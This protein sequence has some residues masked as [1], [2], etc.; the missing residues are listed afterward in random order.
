LSWNSEH[1]QI[2]SARVAPTKYP[3]IGSNSVSG[4]GT[5]EIENISGV[6]SLSTVPTHQ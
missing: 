1:P 5:G 6:A 2:A 3:M 4:I